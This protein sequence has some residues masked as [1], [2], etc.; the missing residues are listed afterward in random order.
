MQRFRPIYIIIP[1]HN[2]LE[3]TKECLDSIYS[4]TYR[5]FQVIVIDDGSS[6]GTSD[7]IRKNYPDVKVLKGDGNL[8]WTGA[9]NLGVEY[10]LKECRDDD[11]ILTLNNDTCLPS[12]YLETMISL[13]RETPKALIGSIAHDYRAREVV[14]DEGVR[15]QW[16][17]AKFARINSSAG[18]KRTSFYSVSALPGRGTLIPAAAF[19]TLGPFDAQNFPHYSADYDFSLRAY[20]AGYALL[21]HPDCYLYS[22]TDLTG[23]SNLHNTLSFFVWLQSFRS[24]KSP[25]NLRIR[26]RFG[27]KHAPLLCRPTYIFCDFARVVF[28]TFRNQI[29]NILRRLV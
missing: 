1:V 29:K 23:I 26:F 12:V 25:N 10:A 17:S 6:D 14:I 19:A 4:Q 2:R 8:W 27:L 22:R 9:T 21:L 20:K 13:A 11:Y 7:Y 24:I 3:A 28:G 18:N 15:I 5:N 16:I